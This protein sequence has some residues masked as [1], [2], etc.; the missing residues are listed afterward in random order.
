[1]NEVALI[2]PRHWRTHTDA[3]G[4]LWL[5]IDKADTGTN[6]LSSEVLLEAGKILDQIEVRPP[7]ALVIYSAKKSGFIAGAD[8]REFT[9]LETPEQAYELIRGGQSLFDRIEALRF[10]TVAAINGFAL[11]GGLELALACKYRVL[12]DDPSVTLGLPEVRLGIHPGFGGTVRSVRL[13]GVL[14]AM[15]MMLTGRNVR[16]REALR[17]GLVDQL[18]PARHLERAAREIALHPPRRKPRNPL[19][20]LLET[21][22]ARGPVAAMLERRVAKEARRQHYPAPYAII[23]LWRRHAGDPASRALEAEARS[24]AELMCTSTSRNLVRVFLLQDR[25]KS[26]AGRA[27]ATLRHVHVVGAGTMGGDIAAWCALQG[28]RVSLQD[29]EPK[30]IAPAI[31]RADGLFR[32]RA[33]EP[34]LVQAARDR[35]LPDH[36]GHGVARADVVIEAIFEN[37]EAKQTLFRDL[38]P[39][40]QRGALLATN[41]S[42]IRLEALREVLADR[43]RLVGL[44]FFNPVAQMP[45]VEVISAEG[46][47]PDAIATALVFVKRIGKLPLPCASRPGFLVNRVLMPYLMEAFRAGEEGIA[48]P[49]I[50][51]AATDFGMPMGPVELADT[52]GL[53]VCLSVARVFADAFGLEVPARLQTMVERGQLGRKSGRGFYTWRNGKPVKPRVD[54]AAPADLGDRLILPMLNEAVACLREGVVAEADLVDA[55][56]IFGTGFAPFTGGPLNYARQ[57]GIGN[58]VAALDALRDRYG[59]RFAPDEGWNLL[60]VE[61]GASRVVET[62]VKREP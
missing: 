57:R 51:R 53:D 12:V 19:H 32:K 62:A 47:S 20:K 16:P 15:S 23:E 6:V 10:T 44:H 48:P 13:V 3:D 14:A 8:I 60:V 38:E 26:L 24:I 28:L 29:R 33:R 25:L 39:R 36:R 35:L 46:T 27:P 59:P 2:E 22:P 45:L 54:G 11:G 30:Y 61:P 21:A 37:L 42:S 56:V 41:T 49:L 31:A 40:L 17:I 7:R 18:V 50:D 9:R 43:S 55:G 58:I 52:V 5:G 34:R 4:I 1:M